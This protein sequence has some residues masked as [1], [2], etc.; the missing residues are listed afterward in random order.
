MSSLP[1]ISCNV[2]GA[3]AHGRCTFQ[4][5]VSDLRHYA[6]LLGVAAPSSIDAVTGT[7]QEIAEYVQLHDA[8]TS[9][10]A[11]LIALEKAHGSS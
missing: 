9:R 8:V 6:R 11:Q 5:T 4:R 2:C 7:A 10:I 3:S 1:R